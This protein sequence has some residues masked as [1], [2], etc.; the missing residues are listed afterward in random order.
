MISS[1]SNPQMK[2]IIQL[3]KK[4]RYRREQ[5]QYVVEGIRM[6]DE[7]PGP[8]LI[9]A[10]LSESYAG[11]YGTPDH[12]PCEVVSDRVFA[13]ISDTKTPQGIL[14]LVKMQK[15]SL[16]QMLREPRVNLILL[17]DLRDPGNMGTIVRCAE[18]AGVTGIIASD[19][20]VDLYN[21]KVIRSTMGSVFRVP[22]LFVPDF[23]KLLVRLKEENVTLY[24]AH[25]A[26]SSDYDRISYSDRSGVMIGNEAQGLSEEAAGMADTLVKI[27]MMGKVESLNAAI[28]SSVFMYEIFRQ[29]RQREDK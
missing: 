17:E 28:A 2:H 19:T 14:A 8:L 13:Q 5:E 1:T 21:P 27:P 15:Y 6:V 25:L 24:A 3:A 29:K 16:E 11:K 9:R 20:S 12:Y 18:G 22:V 26:G 10:Y 7:I 4:A 23:K